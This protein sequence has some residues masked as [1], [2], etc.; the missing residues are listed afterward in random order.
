MPERHPQIVGQRSS[1]AL[2]SG[3]FVIPTRRLLSIVAMLTI[4]SA[5]TDLGEQPV[6][7]DITNA[8]GTVL[9]ASPSFYVIQCDFPLQISAATFYPTNLTDTFRK[10]G[11][12]VRFSGQIASSP[13][14]DYLYLPVRLTFIERL[15]F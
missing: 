6:T 9:E 13:G 2:L 15:Q 4:L 1:I 14:L 10:N 7:F 11:L 5:C 8:T 12:R 3:V